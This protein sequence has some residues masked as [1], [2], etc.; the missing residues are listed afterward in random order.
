MSEQ[1]PLTEYLAENPRMMGALLTLCVLLTQ[2]TA[3]IAGNGSTT[4]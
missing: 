1:N 4:S 3:V 2:A